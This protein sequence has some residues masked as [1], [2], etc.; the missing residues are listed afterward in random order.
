MVKKQKSCLKEG[1]KVFVLLFFPNL[2]VLKVRNSVTG[3]IYFS[4]QQIKK[5]KGLVFTK[6]NKNQ[7]NTTVYKFIMYVCACVYKKM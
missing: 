2:F 4:C 7:F 1:T 5:N 6:S 3:Q